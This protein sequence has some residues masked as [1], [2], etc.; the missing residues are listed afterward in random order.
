MSKNVLFSG[1]KNV[2]KYLSV[3]MN[4][5]IENVTDDVVFHILYPKNDKDSVSII[6]SL[7]KKFKIFGYGV[8]VELVKPLSNVAGN[9]WPSS[10]FFP[11]FAAQI[12]PDSLDSVL[13]LDCDTLVVKNIDNLFN[14]KIDDKMVLATSSWIKGPAENYKPRKIN[15][16]FNSGVY[17][18][19]LKKWRDQ[20]IN[21]NFWMSMQSKLKAK[22]L[23]LFDQDLLNEA[24]SSSETKYINKSYNVNPSKYDF[25]KKSDEYDGIKILHFTNNKYFEGKPWDLNLQKSDIDNSELKYYYKIDS[26]I[27]EMVSFWWK[28]AEK[29]EFFDEFIHDASIRK[30]FYVKRAVSH[31]KREKILANKISD[32]QKKNKQ[33][34]D[35]ELQ[36]HQLMNYGF[37][38]LV[39]FNKSAFKQTKEQS[40]SIFTRL[41]NDGNYLVFPFGNKIQINKKYRLQIM[42]KSNKSTTSW[43]YIRQNHQNKQFLGKVQISDVFK[44]ITIDFQPNKLSYKDLA[45]TVENN[46]GISLFIKNILIFE[47]SELN[48]TNNDLKDEFFQKKVSYQS[49]NSSIKVPFDSKVK[50][51]LNSNNIF[52]SLRHKEQRFKDGETIVIG[53][54]AVI[55]EF[56]SFEG[57]SNLFTMGAFSYSRSNLPVNTIVGRYSSIA[58][59]ATRMG[60]SHP[61]ERFTTSNLTYETTSSAFSKYFNDNDQSFENFPTVPNSHKNFQ[62]IV[63]GNDVWIG[64]DVTFSGNGIKIGNGAIVASKA[65]VTKDVPPYAVVGGIPA[66]VIKYRFPDDIIRKLEELKWWQYDPIQLQLSSTDLPIEDFI[67]HVNKLKQNDSLRVYEPNYVTADLF[68]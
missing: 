20:N 3:L 12:L 30:N 52:S 37:N 40:I 61:I 36:S 65:V 32:F 58:P 62:P 68:L 18:I 39:L 66:K 64:Q 38:S 45:I 54:K 27:Q 56:A 47:D 13:V 7:S 8:D 29:S 24:F 17:I 34:S 26:V 23:T 55:E 22:K 57:G 53:K 60:T 6:E 28:F 33:I 25:A 50:K 63:I 49:D 4:S 31:F 5:V 43:L 51:L 14:I 15:Y 10:A 16:D 48:P 21:L 11:L 2:L 42:I 9:T 59:G 1:D 67:K 41:I 46:S 44:T 35:N 19:N